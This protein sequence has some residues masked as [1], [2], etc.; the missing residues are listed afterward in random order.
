[1]TNIKNKQTQLVLASLT[2]M[3]L[4]LSASCT[5]ATTGVAG[6]PLEGALVYTS[7]NGMVGT[8]ITAVTPTGL[9]PEGATAS[10][11]INPELPSGL[12]INADTGEIFGTPLAAAA[13]SDFTV[14]ATGTG[15]YSGTLEATV[16]ITVEEQ[17]VLESLTGPLSY[18]A[19][20]GTVGEQIIAVSPTGLGPEGATASYAIKDGAALPSSL[21]INAATGEISGT[22]T[23]TGSNTYTIVA[24]GTGNYTGSLEATVS[25]TIQRAGTELTGTL[26]YADI[27]GTVG[28]A[29]TATSPT[30]IVPA[31]AT[32]SF[33]IKE[34][35][36][37]LPDGISLNPDTG[38]ISGMPN[39]SG[40]ASYAIVAT[41][42]GDDYYGTLEG[43]VSI[44]IS[45]ASGILL[46]GTLS[47][48]DITGTAGTAITAV[49]PTGLG[50]A[51]A[52]AT[53][54]IKAGTP[55]LPD[56]LEI[57]VATGEISGI[58]TE[59]AA[60]VT[61]TVVAAGTAP[62]YTGFLEATLSIDIAGIPLTGTLVYASIDGV[63]G[64]EIAAVTPTGLDS[65][66]TVSVIYT[67]NPALPEGLGINRDTGVISGTPIAASIIDYLVTV[68][69]TGIYTGSLEATIAIMIPGTELTGTL[70]YANIDSVV[71]QDITAV[72]PTELGPEN[73]T[74]K[75]TIDPA[76]PDGLA[77]DPATGEISGTA[78]QSSEGYNNR[79]SVAGDNIFTVT[80]TGTGIYT[81]S[82][83]AT[84][85]IVISQIPME[86]TLVYATDITG[87]V[88]TDIDVIT[89]TLEV[90]VGATSGIVNAVE[91]PLPEGLNIDTVTGEIS[92]T[93]AGPSDGTYTIL[94]ISTNYDYSSTISTEVRIVITE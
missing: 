25:I 22:P 55:A 46:T 21:Q 53:Y 71:Q 7:I 19:I 72:S 10:Y 80:A 18:A 69:G 38:V 13:A 88:G 66:D 64:T 91:T 75:Y 77:L 6:N 48:T 47:Y 26:T 4:L 23:Q 20:T 45:E 59:P 29:I 82:F 34:G 1:M 2:M 44:E 68:T 51:G 81:G 60:S 62:T 36:T 58:P 84:L 57:N 37:A 33:V 92:G 24:T 90:V 74:I 17:V 30:G 67:V 79:N 35:T 89:P 85:Q 78:N 27:T 65:S 73:A 56:G 32:A 50:P 87:T 42:T 11:A 14:T 40:T 12:E 94:V 63:I 3:V 83:E 43:T 16:S 49:T 61:Y 93:P 28:T 54:S 31:E 5:P 70:S 8:A 76:L 9:G 41:G 86:G 15:D 52:M 39:A